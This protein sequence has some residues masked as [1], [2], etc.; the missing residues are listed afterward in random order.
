MR[1]A[2]LDERGHPVPVGV[3]G[4]IF[5]G[6][7]GVTQGYLG[8]PDLT[9]ERFVPDPARPESAER[10]Y[11]SGDLAR[12][13]E[14]GNLEFLGR[15]DHQM[16]LRSYRIE[17]GELESHIARFPGV[18]QAVVMLREASDG[19]QSLV[20]YLA[21]EER[22]TLDLD[23]L[24][25]FLGERLIQVMIPS[26]FVLLDQL[27]LTANGKIDRRALRDRPA[28]AGA[29]LPVGDAFRPGGAT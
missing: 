22:E 10:L 16:K 15:S 17:P 7:C 21:V 18:R 27:P 20:A 14:D 1:V 24:K 19:W 23:G 4:E 12:Y 6:G 26:E 13:H 28:S 2:L 9:A 29:V 5:I 3:A 11:R 25:S 8:R